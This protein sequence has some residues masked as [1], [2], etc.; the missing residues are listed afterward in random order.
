MIADILLRTSTTGQHPEKQKEDCLALAKSKGYDIGE[1]FL[2]QVSG[3]KQDIAREGYDAIKIKARDRKID[4]VI[5]WAIDRWVRNRDTLLEDI[6]IL[7]SYG[8]KLHSVREAWLEAINIDGALGKTIQEFL[9]GLIGSLAEMESKRKSE[10]MIM[11]FANH[12][13]NKWGRP[14]LNL[15]IDKQI[16]ELYKKEISLREISRQVFYWDNNRNKKFVSIG[17]VHKT[18]KK[19]KQGGN[20]F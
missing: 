9:L 12:K 11:A 8:V 18:I 1:I 15:D 17:Y 10:R 2:E 6:T 16:I 20:S 4:A 14:S 5:V 13:G 7:R 3:Y 19:F